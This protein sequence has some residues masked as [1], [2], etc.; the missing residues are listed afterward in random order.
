MRL[1]DDM[2]VKKAVFG[3]NGDSVAGLGG[4]LRA[5]FQKCLYIISHDVTNVVKAYFCGKE[6]PRYITHTNLI[7]L[8]KNEIPRT[9]LDIR[10]ISL[11]G[12]VNKVISMVVCDRLV[13]FLP[14]IISQSKYLLIKNVVL[15][16]EIKRDIN[17]RNKHTNV[18]IKLDMTKA[19]DKVSWIYLTKVLRKFGF[20]K[21]LIDMV[22]RL[23]SNNWYSVLVNGLSHGLFQS[24]KGL[25]QGD[26]LSST[27]FII[28]SEVMTRGLNNLHSD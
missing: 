8:P 10:P 9:F 24:T 22:W 6:L 20:C 1:L 27:L 17:R 11:S 13:N 14:K 26:P 23:P 18:V 15:A 16:Q 25:E 5:F 3:L 7:M 4:F 19:Y 12:F 28:A 21:V 2:E